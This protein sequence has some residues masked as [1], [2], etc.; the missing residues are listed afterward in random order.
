MGI[1]I[2]EKSWYFNT[3]SLVT[4]RRQGIVPDCILWPKHW[5]GIDLWAFTKG[6][7][8][9]S[10]T[11][12]NSINWTVRPSA[13]FRKPTSNQ[14]VVGHFLNVLNWAKSV[15]HYN[16]AIMSAMTSQ[17][18]TLTIVYSTVYSGADQRKHHSSASMAFVCGIH[19]LPV[20]SS[21]TKSL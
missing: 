13:L 18:T 21:R 17:I 9:I 1:P 4:Y 10:S 3:V 12:T 7:T 14:I 16:D 8:S 2:P 11:Q 20:N 5:P 19:R 15:S 6:T